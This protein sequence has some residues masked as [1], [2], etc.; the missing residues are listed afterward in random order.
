MNR[1]RA[2]SQ[3]EQFLK[4]HYDI[5]HGAIIVK[6]GAEKQNSKKFATQAEIQITKSAL[7]RK[8]L[9]KV[10]Y[11]IL[12]RDIIVG[13]GAPKSKTLKYLQYKLKFK[14][15]RASSHEEQLSKI[16]YENL[17]ESHNCGKGGAE[18]HN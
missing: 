6:G 8:Q 1:K 2:P 5:L 3:E 14:S 13:K 17:T 15:Q 10:R 4:I 12:Q 18:K 9:S 11:E 7:P 16:R